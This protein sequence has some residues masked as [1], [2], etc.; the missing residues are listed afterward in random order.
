MNNK[1]LSILLLFFC[2]SVL[3]RASACD[4]D[5]IL[6]K[7]EANFVFTGKVIS[8]TRIDTPYRK[9]EI[10]FRICKIIKGKEDRKEIKIYTPCLLEACCGIPFTIGDNYYVTAFLKDD[11]LYTNDC[12]ATNKIE[13]PYTSDNK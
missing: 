4:C 11:V 1:F 9:Y 10:A 12:C 3:N 8:I 13:N 5:N 7:K 2:L 6:D